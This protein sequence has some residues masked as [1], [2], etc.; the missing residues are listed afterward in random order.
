MP[1][2]NLQLGA[3]LLRVFVGP[4][5]GEQ[6]HPCLLQQELAVHDYISVG[7]TIEC[8]ALSPPLLI[9]SSQ[10]PLLTRI[11]LV[12]QCRRRDLPRQ[13]RFSFLNHWIRLEPWRGPER[14]LVRHVMRSLRR[15]VAVLF[16]PPFL[17]GRAVRGP[18]FRWGERFVPDAQLRHGSGC[19]FS[20]LFGRVPE[21][22]RRL[23]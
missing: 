8:G 14:G 20:Q 17:K 15:S 16:G 21:F 3:K 23:N 1:N 2:L 13:E 18:L 12:E 9:A 22:L 10:R 5:I 19:G 11:G 6:G 4:S 7:L